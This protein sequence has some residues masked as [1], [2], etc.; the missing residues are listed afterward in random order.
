MNADLTEEEMRRALFGTAKPE[1]VPAPGVPEPVTEVVFTKPVAAPV[2]KKKV[3]KALY[4]LH[5]PHIPKR[6]ADN[7][8]CAPDFHQP[9]RAKTGVWFTTAVPGGASPERNSRR[10]NLAAL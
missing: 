9:A 6:I 2:A 3:T 5:E 8:C 10:V 1:D 7:G 4:P